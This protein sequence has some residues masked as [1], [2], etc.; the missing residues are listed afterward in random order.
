M[1]KKQL[2][3]ELMKEKELGK[4]KMIQKQLREGQRLK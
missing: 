4:Q 2:E 3:L 1:L